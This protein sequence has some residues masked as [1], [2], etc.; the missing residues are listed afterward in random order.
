MQEASMRKQQKSDRS[1]QHSQGINK[2]NFKSNSKDKA[3]I[4]NKYLSN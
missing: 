3:K 2:G 1:S 4:D